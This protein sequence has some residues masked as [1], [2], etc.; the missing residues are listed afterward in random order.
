MI[1]WKYQQLRVSSAKKRLAV[2]EQLADTYSDES[3]GPLIFALKDKDPGVRSA[4]AKALVRYYDRRAVE[5]LIHVLRDKVPL[6]RAAAA[7][8]LG[9]LGDAHAINPLV[10]LLRDADPVVRGIA[11]RSL[12]RLGWKPGSDSQRML[13]ILAMGNLQQLLTLGPEG[14]GLCWSVA[15]RH[16]EQADHRGE[17]VGRGQRSARAADD[18][19]GVAENQ[20]GGAHRGPRHARTAGRPVHVFGSGEIVAG[21]QCQRARRGRGNGDAL[22]RCARG[23][24]AREMPEGHVMGSAPGGGGRTGLFGRHVRRW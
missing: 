20:P 11:V 4:A 3:V 17:G 1:W 8:T 22:R 19:G 5:P 9:H 2:V 18:A 10:G 15:H 13:Q 6:A 16:A 24:R 21:R 7:E 12:N 14:V 23:A